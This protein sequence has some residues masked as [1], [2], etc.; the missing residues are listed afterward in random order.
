MARLRSV[1]TQGNTTNGL[2]VAEDCHNMIIESKGRLIATLGVHD[3]I[4]V[5]TEDA[6]LVCAR[7]RAQDIR[8][9]IPTINKALE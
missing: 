4:V 8:N 5:E 6:V 9:L 2:V 1:D 3:L 7:D